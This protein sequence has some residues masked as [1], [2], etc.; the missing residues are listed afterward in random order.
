MSC[1]LNSLKLGDLDQYFGKGPDFFCDTGLTTANQNHCAHFVCH[2]LNL[3]VGRPL[4]GDLKYATRGRGVTMRVNDVFNYC[5][6]KGSF[7][8][9]R[10][11]PPPMAGFAAFFVVATLTDNITAAGDQITM[12]D[13]PH[14]HVGIYLKGEVWNFSNSHHQ[15]VRDKL[16]A[17]FSRMHHAY[18]THTT[19]LYAYRQ[20][21]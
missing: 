10:K 16:H 2:A 20:D 1:K 8:N 7:G 3:R 12:H 9:D 4:C 13:N 5:T 14:K 18:G 19:F 11:I 6:V 17:F 21:I 15:V